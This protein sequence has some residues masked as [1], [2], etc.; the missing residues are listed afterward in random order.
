[1]ER[2]SRWAR[3]ALSNWY[4]TVS[5]SSAFM[6]AVPSISGQALAMPCRLSALKAATMSLDM[7]VLPADLAQPVVAQHIGL[8]RLLQ[9]QRVDTSCVPRR[10]SCSRD[11]RLS[12][13]SALTRHAL[14]GELDGHQHG[15]QTMQR[16]GPSAPAPSPCRLRMLEQLAL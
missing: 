15:L 13:C 1:M 6:R 2:T 9:Y 5:W 4:I 11:S 14:Q 16:D 3:S 8:W 12:T 7:V 10:R